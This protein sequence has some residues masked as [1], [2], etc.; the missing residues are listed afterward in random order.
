M[1]R[2]F[3]PADAV[4]V[5]VTRTDRLGDLILTAP[6]FDA[7]KQHF[8]RAR[9]SVLASPANAGIAAR[10][11]GIDAVEVDDV[12]ARHSGWRGTLTLAH[13]LRQLGIDIILF[14]NSKH[15]LALGAWLARIPVRIGSARRG[16]SILYTARVHGRRFEHETDRML[17]LLQPL[18]INATSGVAAQCTVTE[19]DRAAVAQLLTTRG[20]GPGQRLAVVHP[21]NSGN[22]MN[23]SPAW[24]VTLADALH[25]A[26][27]TVV[28]TGT[29]ADHALT[30]HIAGAMQ[31]SALDLSGDLTVGELGALLARSQLCIASSTGPTHLAAAVGTPT[32]GL[33]SPLAD[34]ERWLPRGVTVEVLRPGV[35]M[36]CPTCLG[37][38]CAFFNCMDRIAP[39]R[40]V[41]AGDALA[42][43]CRPA[44]NRINTGCG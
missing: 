43:S 36:T 14:G 19:Q 28:L 21:G 11:R 30:A 39:E 34:Q 7:V 33:Y 17:R 26:G 12:E 29:A 1:S 25:E 20:L 4:H 31:H 5:L 44:T 24:Y 18:G 32:V 16:Y 41:A 27:Y 9:V 2:R 23:A 6:L 35:G 37:P 40:V 42:S 3:T 13:R 38:R 10:L 22:A 15:R 8:P